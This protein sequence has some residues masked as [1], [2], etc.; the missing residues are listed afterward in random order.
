[1]TAGT[2][3]PACSAA[4]IVDSESED[5]NTRPAI[6]V[7][8]P[9]ADLAGQRDADEVACPSRPSRLSARTA[10]KSAGEATPMPRP[11]TP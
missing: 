6:A 1:M 9:D 4:R 7:P 2:C 11:A 3:A 10:V 8:T 5:S